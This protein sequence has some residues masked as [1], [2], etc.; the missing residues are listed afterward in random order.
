MP[1]QKSLAPC[2][3]HARA[4]LWSLPI[5][6]YATASRPTSDES[7][8]AVQCLNTTKKRVAVYF[9]L[10]E[11]GK[12]GLQHKDAVERMIEELRDVWYVCFAIKRGE[13][14]RRIM[15]RAIYVKVSMHVTA[16]RNVIAHDIER[17]HDTFLS[18]ADQTSIVDDLADAY[19]ALQLAIEQLDPMITF[20]NT[21]DDK[22]NAFINMVRTTTSEV[23]DMTRRLDKF[24]SPDKSLND[25][26]PEGGAGPWFDPENVKLREIM[27][28]HRTPK[29]QCT[30]PLTQNRAELVIKRAI[31]T[32]SLKMEHPDIL[33]KFTQDFEKK[34]S[35]DMCKWLTKAYPLL[36]N[37]ETKRNTDI[38][39]HAV[40]CVEGLF[41]LECV[42]QDPL[43]LRMC[44]MAYL[45]G[46]LTFFKLAVHEDGDQF[47]PGPNFYYDSDV[48]DRI[49]SD[50]DR[51]MSTISFGEMGLFINK[52][53]KSGA[54]PQNNA[55][56]LPVVGV[57]SSGA[58]LTL[59]EIEQQNIYGLL[60]V[61]TTDIICMFFDCFV[62]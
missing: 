17:A 8:A 26:P 57:D 35:E 13:E 41:R 34:S 21:H 56:H 48:L 11:E 40:L 18:F 58:T 62:I 31:N 51:V 10:I 43:I 50:F 12:L 42:Q 9:K 61:C 14:A 24:V 30:Y 44:T 38:A 37:V 4:P 59:N 25:T 52:L 29:P 33:L 20:E 53:R 28:G 16:A 49:I 23:R 46:N 1:I 6:S 19:K 5:K 54:I 45:Y 3:E 32:F 15:M 2:P 47:S 36:L 7:A 27:R 55:Q 22:D 60:R 39:L